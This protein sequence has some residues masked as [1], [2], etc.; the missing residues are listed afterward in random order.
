MATFVLTWNPDLWNWPTDEFERAVQ[1]TARGHR[2]PD[3]W[4]VGRRSGGIVVG[5][6]AF[7]LRQRRDRG[8]VASGRFVS[9]IEPGPH[10]DGSG[11]E[12][13]FA[14]VE[15]DTVLHWDDRLPLEVLHVAVPEVAW[16]FRSSGVELAPDSAGKVERL[17]ANHTDPLL[18]RLPDEIPADSTFSEGQVT[19]IVVNRYER[20]PRARAACLAHWRSDCVVCGMSF[21]TRYGDVGKGF[22]HVHHLVELSTVGDDYRVDAINDLRPVCPN[23]HAMLHQGRPA[24]AIGELELLLRANRATR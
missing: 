22:I 5:D 19:R 8:L 24:L 16:N 21:E 9:E 3:S 17:W 15:W 7:L 11:R 2:Q 1:T 23:C 13:P 20:D 14:Q 6:R 4:S 10:W 12:A 18:V